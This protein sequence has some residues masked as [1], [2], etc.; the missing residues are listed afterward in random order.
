L[1][2]QDVLQVQGNVNQI[3]EER[4]L[5]YCEGDGSRQVYFLECGELHCTVYGSRDRGLSGWHGM[6]RLA[7]S[8][9]KSGKQSR[10]FRGCVDACSPDSASAIEMEGPDRWWGG[11][12]RVLSRDCVPCERREAAISIRAPPVLLRQ[13]VGRRCASRPIAC[14]ACQ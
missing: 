5:L 6:A 10:P 14:L 9:E 2:R 7:P 8:M 4:L 13:L 12:G 11:G 1:E 3:T